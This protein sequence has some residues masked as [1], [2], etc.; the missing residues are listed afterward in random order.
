MDTRRCMAAV[1]AARHPNP[2][3]NPDPDPNP[4]PNPDPNPNRCQVWDTSGRDRFKSLA[5]TFYRRAHSV[6]LVFDVKNRESFD[7]FATPNPSPNPQPE[8][9]PRSSTPTLTPTPTLSPNPNP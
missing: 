7:K 3:P 9:E 1:G 8:P 2:N 6:L 4:N 5:L